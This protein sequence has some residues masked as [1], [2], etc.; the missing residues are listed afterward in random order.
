M[1]LNDPFPKELLRS[2]SK[3]GANLTYIPVSEVIARLNDVLGVDGWSYQIMDRWTS[4]ERGGYPVWMMAHVRLTVYDSKRMGPS[5][6][7]DGI[8]GQQVKCKK[9]SDEP[10]DIGDEW[11][12]AVSDALKKA[13]QAFGVGLEL[14]RT[15]EA[16][17]ATAPAPPLDVERFTKTCERKGVPFE[18]VA[19]EFYGHPGSDRPPMTEADLPGLMATLNELAGAKTTVQEAFGASTEPF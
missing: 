19:L 13:A 8:G 2:T 17:A 15:E 11:K 16:L 7:R 6:D 10:V 9:N 4:G 5:V 18:D 12:G 1:N 3:G 14:A